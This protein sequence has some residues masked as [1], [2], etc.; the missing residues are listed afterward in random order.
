MY[1]QFRER[2]LKHQQ[3][4]KDDGWGSYEGGEEGESFVLHLGTLGEIKCGQRGEGT[5]TI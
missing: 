3:R 1:T 5:Q 4:L 2:G